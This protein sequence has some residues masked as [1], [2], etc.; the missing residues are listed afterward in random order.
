MLA[1]TATTSAVDDAATQVNEEH[2]YK[3]ELT[4]TIQN[5]VITQ[6]CK[7]NMTH[8]CMELSLDCTARALRAVA[9]PKP[10]PV[11]V[12]VCVRPC[13]CVSVCVPKP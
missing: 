9:G 3:E 4:A 8:T 6:M 2:V 11:R 13:V 7:H 10:T 1:T 5:D 12:C